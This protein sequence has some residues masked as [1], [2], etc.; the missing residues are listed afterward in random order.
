MLTLL[1]IENIAVIEKIEI[2]FGNGFNVLTGETGA[3][4]SIVI[5]S[6]EAALGWRTSKDLVRSGAQSGLVS[7]VFTPDGAEAWCREH[8]LECEDELI[9]TR[10]LTADG[11]SSCRINGTPVPAAQLRELG[12][13]LIDIH[14]Q[15]DG[16]KLLSERFHRQYLDSYA[17]LSPLLDEHSVK[18]AE[19]EDV[20]RE[21]EALSMDEGEKARRTDMLDYQIKELE[22]ANLSPGEYEEKNRRRE[23]LKSAGK[24][25]ETVAEAFFALYGGDSSD[26]AVSLIGAAAGAISY[27]TKYS[28]ELSELASRLDELKINAEDVAEE[29]RDLR[30]RLEFS[31]EELD[32]LDSRLDKL[33]RI[34][35]KYNCIDETQ[36]LAYLKASKEERDRIGYSDDRLKKL[37]AK[38]LECEKAARKTAKTL[39]DKRWEAGEKLATQI[40]TEL[41]ELS[42]AGARFYVDIVETELGKFGFD[43]VS[44]SV[45]A[46]TG[47]QAGRISKVAS[48]GE[49]SRIMLAMKKVLA[50]CDAVNAMVFDE[51]DTGVSGIAAQRVA[52]KLASISRQKQ[53]ICVTHLPQ[54]AA[55]ADIQFSIEKSEEGGRTYTRVNRL[56]LNGRTKEIARLTG[57]DHV[58]PTTLAA[59]VEL[60]QAAERYKRIS[61]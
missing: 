44:F 27:G 10:R 6:L 35:K 18:Y 51:I 8:E 32:R 16:Q 33:R 55:M 49:L 26:G 56:D 52:E 38:L 46:N 19:Y 39:S 31:P 12:L 11:K 41:Q 57:G 47:E 5:D 40:E 15:G 50:S 22:D 59:A 29:L 7:A 34:F 45:A 60:L 13:L 37:E 20:K 28:G 9:L 14:G 53:V 17:G 58:T 30:D 42:M 2:E 61:N 36:A 25:S 54:I 43:N 24:I 48:G 3:G 4:K 21:I 1:H 23:F